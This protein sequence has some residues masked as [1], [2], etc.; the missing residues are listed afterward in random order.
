MFPPCDCDAV[1]FVLFQ[2]AHKVNVSAVQRLFGHMQVHHA[3]QLYRSTFHGMVVFAV[4]YAL[5][6]DGFRMDLLP[7]QLLGL[8]HPPVSSIRFLGGVVRW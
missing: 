6:A 5:S 8:K 3:M 1:V 4:V 2:D 7:L